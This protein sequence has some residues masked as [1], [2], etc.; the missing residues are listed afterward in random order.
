MLEEVLKGYG[1]TLEREILVTI[2]SHK[3]PN[4]M[5]LLFQPL[6]IKLQY[7]THNQIDKIAIT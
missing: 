2:L 5:T 3:I 1:I 6:T 4:S 7:I